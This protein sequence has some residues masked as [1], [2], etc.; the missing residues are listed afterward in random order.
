MQDWINN[1]I[2]GD[3][4]ALLREMPSESVSLVITSPPYFQQRE[5]GGEGI[6]NEVDIEEYLADLLKIFRECVRVI[7]PSGSIVWNLGDKYLKSNLMLIPHRFA[8]AVAASENVRLVNTITWVKSNPTPRQ[9]QRRLVNSVEPFF[10]FVKSDD[11]YYNMAAFMEDDDRPKKANG[12]TAQ[13]GKRYFELIE[14]SELSDGD[15]SKARI[16]LTQVI[17]EV[18]HGELAG[19]RMKIRGIHSEPFGGQEGGRKIQ[20][21]KQG[22][23]IIRI[24][25]NKL[26]RD[27]IETPVESVKGCRHPAIYPVALVEE[28]LKLL[29]CP[30]EIVL[31]PFMGSGSTAIACQNLE[32]RYIGFEINPEY[33]QMAQER[34]T[35]A[36]ISEPL[37]EGLF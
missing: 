6:G 9:F 18:K 34:I 32:R 5:Y 22:F 31:D 1:I 13:L 30:G 16:A 15:K 25:G 10:H 33:C 35:S 20:L 8:I 4:L 28:F 19:F 21:E 36:E 7:T 2:C 17:Q 14:Q 29:T 3:S 37:Q 11:Y 24:H 26:K 27:V 12:A 23:T